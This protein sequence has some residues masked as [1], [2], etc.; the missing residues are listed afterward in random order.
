[1][2]ITALRRS[3]DAGKAQLCRAASRGPS[4]P[5]GSARCSLFARDGVHRIWHHIESIVV[6]VLFSTRAGEPAAEWTLF[7]LLLGDRSEL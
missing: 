4:V 5:C 3:W 2:R 6:R 7:L 1:M